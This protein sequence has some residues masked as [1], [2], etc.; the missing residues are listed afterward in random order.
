MERTPKAGEFYRHFKN[1]LYQ[2]VTVAQ[3]SETGE[4]FVIY[5]ALYGDYGIY[6]R[7]REMFLSEVDH[8]KY[9]DI[10]EKYRYMV[11]TQLYSMD[12]K[13]EQTKFEFDR[14]IVHLYLAIQFRRLSKQVIVEIDVNKQQY[15]EEQ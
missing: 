11:G 1:N 12:V 6:A 15:D 8:E 4:G 5:Q 3:H 7:P 14:Q 13:F 9:P 10:K 2:I